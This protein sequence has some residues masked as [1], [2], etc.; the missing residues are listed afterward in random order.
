MTWNEFRREAESRGF[1]F[2]RH[3]GS[4]DVYHHSVTHERLYIERHGNQ[5]IRKGLMN[6]LLKQLESYNEGNN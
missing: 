1:V 3:G 5:E 6:T 4:H 2:V